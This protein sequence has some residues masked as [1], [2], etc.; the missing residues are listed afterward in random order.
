E[1]DMTYDWASPMTPLWTQ[2]RTWF[3]E[4]L[5]RTNVATRMGLGLY[6]TF[7]A[8]GLPAP[9]QRLECALGGGD[10]VRAWGWA[11]VMRGVLPLLERLDIATA[12]ELDAD[13]LADR[14]EHDVDAAGGIV[15]WP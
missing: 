10:R 6:S 7:I 13:T 4:A 11:N 3:V 8:A 5:E 1:G 9:E 14:L 2:M 15:I 12:D